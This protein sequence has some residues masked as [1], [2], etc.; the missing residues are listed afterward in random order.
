[1]NILNGANQ[2]RRY[3]TGRR[4]IP[5][6]FDTLPKCNAC[7]LPIPAVSKHICDMCNETIHILGLEIDTFRR[8]KRI[9][10]FLA[11]CNNC[12]VLI[13]DKSNSTEGD[14]LQIAHDII[15]QDWF[16]FY[17]TVEREREQIAIENEILDCDI[18]SLQSELFKL[19]NLEQDFDFF[20][21]HRCPKYH[22][23]DNAHRFAC[24]NNIIQFFRPPIK[25]S[26]AK[27]CIMSRRY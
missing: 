3:R 7:K 17:Q 5:V 8:L 21:T 6:N 24:T 2:Q 20:T 10:N 13:G 19:E 26:H 4:Q 14:I 12:K 16:Q 25:N 22:H 27:R 18:R 9:D 11:V 15:E 1:M 23:I